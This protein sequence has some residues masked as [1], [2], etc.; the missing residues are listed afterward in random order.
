[1]N[2][3]EAK[4]QIVREWLNR[5]VD[6]RTESEAAAFSL[7]HAHASSPFAFKC[8]GDRYQVIMGWLSP[9]IKKN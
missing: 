3:S 2:K 7:S 5:P 4:V 8:S 6:Q 9:H 1:M